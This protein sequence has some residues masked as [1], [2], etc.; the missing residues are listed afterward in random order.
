MVSSTFTDLK[1]HRQK[2]IDAIGKYGYMPSVMEWNG[3][4]ADTDVIRSSLTMVRDSAA[5]VGV[6]SHKYGQTPFDPTLNPNRLSITDLEFNEAVR[7]QRRIILFIMGDKHPGTKADFESVPEKLKNS[8]NFVSAL[9]GCERV[10]RPS[11]FTKFL[12][13]SNNSSNAPLLR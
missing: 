6:I 11:G 1:N 5:Y 7:L 10:A 8:R 4:R 9:C 12:R 2:V 3:A 13:V